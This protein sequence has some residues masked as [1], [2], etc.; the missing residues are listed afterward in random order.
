MN[1]V[2]RFAMLI[3]ILYCIGDIEATL[4][5]LTGHS[6]IEIFTYVARSVNG[7]TAVS[8]LIITIFGACA[9]STLSPLPPV[10]SGHSREIAR[11]PTR[12]WPR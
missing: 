8:A 12:A 6:F 10:N 3:A 4:F 7:G 9:I 5:T 11:F 1:G 2:T